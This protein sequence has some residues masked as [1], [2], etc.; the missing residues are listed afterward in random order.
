MGDIYK[1][2]ERDCHAACCRI[3]N[4]PDP[5]VETKAV[6]RSTLLGSFSK[7]KVIGIE[8]SCCI[9]NNRGAQH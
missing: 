2:M 1:A 3:A 9:G 8:L 6:E 7:S 4:F 5:D